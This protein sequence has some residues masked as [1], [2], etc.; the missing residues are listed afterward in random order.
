MKTD[1]ELHAQQA[2]QNYLALVEKVLEELI[3]LEVREQ[4]VDAILE[5]GERTALQRLTVQ[6]WDEIWM[7][8]VKVGEFYTEMRG[9]MLHMGF[10]PCRGNED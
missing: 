1:L 4:G 9:T 6:G 2:V 7:Y 5:Y 3:P 8:D 10:R